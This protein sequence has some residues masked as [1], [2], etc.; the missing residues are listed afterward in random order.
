MNDYTVMGTL[1][2]GAYGEVILAKHKKNEEQEVAIKM[3][4][5]KFL[6]RVKY[7]RKKII[8]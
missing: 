7:K 4:D 1:G 8:I 3:L 6:A 5:K 2:R